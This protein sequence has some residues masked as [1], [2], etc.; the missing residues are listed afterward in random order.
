MLEFFINHF[1]ERDSAILNLDYALLE[2]YKLSVDAGFESQSEYMVEEAR[3]IGVSFLNHLEKIGC[4]SKNKL[5]YCF[6]RVIDK[7]TFL[8]WRPDV[9][10]TF[11]N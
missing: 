5:E 3:K 8:L 6:A 11:G 2:M 4:F 1:R 7:D 10:D 9:T